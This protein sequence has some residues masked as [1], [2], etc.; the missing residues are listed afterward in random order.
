MLI[1]PHLYLGDKSPTEEYRDE[2]TFHHY[3]VVRLW[4]QESGPFLANPALL[5]LATLTQSESPRSLLVQV[6]EQSAIISDREKRQ[7]IS[8]CVEIL[9]GLRFKKDIIRQLFREEIM[10]SSVI[11]Q[12]ILQQGLQRGRREGKEEGQQEGEIALLLRFL[13]RR[14]GEVN[15]ILQEQIRKLSTPA[16]EE[17][18]DALLDFSAPTDL[19]IWLD[20]QHLKE[21][22]ISLIMRQLTRKMGKIEPL[23]IEQ[24]RG[25]SF[26]DLEGLAEAL[27]DFTEVNNLVNWLE[28]QERMKDEKLN[29]NV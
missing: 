24:V 11:Y 12:D 5:P 19:V 10:Q 9:A 6:A 22:E 28:E 3:R 8:G 15:P 27:L 4:E 23:L 7:N 1:F 21:R 18:E 17:L 20:K 25:L 26:E 16:L 29:Y 14:I 2:T 13:K